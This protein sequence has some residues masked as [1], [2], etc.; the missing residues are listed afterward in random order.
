VY[1]CYRTRSPIHVD[2][3]LDEPVWLKTPKSPRF[4]D[5][6]GG[7]PGIYDTRS[8]LLWDDQNL[9]IAFWCEEPFPEAQ[10]TQRD[11][12]IWF[13]NDVEVFIDGGDTY[14]EFEINALNTIYEVFYI[15]KDAYGPGGRFDVP[16][17]DIFKQNALTFGGNHDRTGEYFWKGSHPRENRWAYRSWDFPGLKTAVAIDGKLND[18]STIS[19]GWTLELAFPWIGMKWLANGRSLPPVEGDVWNLFLGRYE[20]MM[21]NGEETHVGWSWDKIGTNDNHHPELFT[22]I[23]FSEEYIEDLN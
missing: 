22:P 6:I 2:G 3:K 5:V 20:K 13:E 15:W 1:K 21:L 4:I 8:A 12:L 14:Y 9:Y 17:F 19:K 18:N 16:E 23:T 7:T 10:I 11:G